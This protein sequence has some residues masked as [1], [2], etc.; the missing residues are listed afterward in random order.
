MGSSVQQAP[1]LQ[2]PQGTQVSLQD[3]ITHTRQPYAGALDF[4]NG[5]STG[6]STAA[7]GRVVTLWTKAAVRALVRV[8]KASQLGAQWAQAARPPS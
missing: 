8:A 3:K 5:S 7:D 4:K 6:L 1:P 2:P